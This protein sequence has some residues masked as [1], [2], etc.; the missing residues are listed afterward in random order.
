[1]CKDFFC[2]YLFLFLSFYQKKLTWTELVMPYRAV[3][4][5]SWMG[6]SCALPLILIN[7]PL[8]ESHCCYMLL[9]L[10]IMVLT[11]IYWTTKTL[12]RNFITFSDEWMS[13]TLFIICCQIYFDCCIMCFARNLFCLLGVVTWLLEVGLGVTKRGVSQLFHN[14]T[15]EYFITDGPVCLFSFLCKLTFFICMW[16]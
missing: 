3:L 9:P 10:W 13:V 16:S 2:F 4:V 14:S 6:H 1:M 5:E 12:E 7:L 8:C 11:V 15:Y